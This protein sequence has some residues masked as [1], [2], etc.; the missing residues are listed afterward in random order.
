MKI[1]IFKVSIEKQTYRSQEC[2][3]HRKNSKN[4]GKTLAAMSKRLDGY[5]IDYQGFFKNKT[6]KFFDKAEKYTHGVFVSQARNIERI[7]ESQPGSDYFP[8]TRST[9][10]EQ[11][12]T[13]PST[14]G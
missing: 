11:S 5:L 12:S 8:D 2:L 10:S 13:T 6:K 4:Y 7:C 3:T 1:I 14:A 9:K